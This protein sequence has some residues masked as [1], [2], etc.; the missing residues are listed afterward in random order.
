MCLCMHTQTVSCMSTCSFIYKRKKRNFFLPF[1]SYMLSFLI[2][3]MFL[4]FFFTFTLKRCI[5]HLHV[6]IICNT[7]AGTCTADGWV[8]EH[9]RIAG[10]PMNSSAHTELR[11]TMLKC[12][13]VF[14]S[15]CIYVCVCCAYMN[16][17][18][19]V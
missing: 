17:N 8:L 9:T 12:V 14:V 11:I 19:R 15:V 3:V 1:L 4:F 7:H 6:P 2:L 18:I 16:V 13:C 10:E 5:L